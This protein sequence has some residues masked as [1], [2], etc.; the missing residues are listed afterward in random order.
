MGP[1]CRVEVGARCPAVRSI[2]VWA[3]PLSYGVITNPV[4]GSP[5]LAGTVQVTRAEPLPGVTVPTTGVPGA[6][7]G[8]ATAI[9]GIGSTA[10]SKVIVTVPAPVDVPEESVDPALV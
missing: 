10:V 1:R 5:P 6:V 9:G 8:G 7:V 3:T 2:G 4:M